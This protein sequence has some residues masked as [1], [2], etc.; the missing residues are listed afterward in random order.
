[1]RGC[2]VGAAFLLLAAT[3]GYSLWQVQQLKAEVASLRGEVAS[4][5]RG[6]PQT[7]LDMAQAA[8]EAARRGDWAEAS[9]QA[10]ALSTRVGKTQAL[11]TRQKEEMERRIARIRADLKRRDRDGVRKLQDPLRDLSANKPPHSDTES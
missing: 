6:R 11:A 9:R 3:T 8:V 10:E 7:A 5:R 1:M 4:V 2:L